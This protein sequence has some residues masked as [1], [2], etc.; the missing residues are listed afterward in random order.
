MTP[1]LATAAT[2]A[3]EVQLD[4]VPLPMTRVGREVSTARASTGTNA[5]P[6]GLPGAGT[7]WVASDPTFALPRA[8]LPA[9][10]WAAAPQAGTAIPDSSEVT[11]TRPRVSR[12][13]RCYCDTTGHM[14]GFRPF[15]GAMP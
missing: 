11:S 13:G 2:T 7:A 3:C 4:G 9:G 12:T 15:N 1:P 14:G 10:G 8:A 5:R 6:L